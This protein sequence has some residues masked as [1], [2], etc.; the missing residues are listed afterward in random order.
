LT[1]FIDIQ[2]LAPLDFKN[3]TKGKHGGIFVLKNNVQKQVY[4]ADKQV[5]DLVLSPS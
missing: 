1:N 5:Q 3:I 4:F 2:K